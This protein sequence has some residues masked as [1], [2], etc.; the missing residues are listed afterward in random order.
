MDY[1]L[2]PHRCCKNII[3]VNT[4]DDPF[5]DPSFE[6]RIFV[7]NSPIDISSF[8]PSHDPN[9]YLRSA[10]PSFVPIQ[11]WFFVRLECKKENSVETQNNKTQNTK[12]MTKHDSTYLVISL[13]RALPRECLNSKLY[14]FIHSLHFIVR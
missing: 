5:I 3:S 13:S 14:I 7:I 1:D 2:H 12:H 11:R 6:S 8:D 10:C 9:N 4:N